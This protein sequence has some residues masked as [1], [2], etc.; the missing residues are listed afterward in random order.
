MIGRQANE[1]TDVSSEPDSSFE[2]LAELYWDS[3]HLS[4]EML[5]RIAQNSPKNYLQGHTGAGNK[6]LCV[7]ASQE[8]SYECAM[9]RAQ[10]TQC[11]QQQ[12]TESCSLIK[13]VKDLTSPKA[14]L[15]CC[16]DASEPTEATTKSND[17]LQEFSQDCYWVA[18]KYI[19]KQQKAIQSTTIETA[20]LR[21][22]SEAS[23]SCVSLSQTVQSADDFDALAEFSVN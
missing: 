6:A 4:D 18:H 15:R 2:L 7:S 9:D 21:T 5:P 14:K 13:K 22:C 16:K 23:L 20:A 1:T 12:G 11:I 8:K 10:E 19:P 3:D 17:W